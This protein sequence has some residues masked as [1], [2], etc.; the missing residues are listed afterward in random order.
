MAMQIGTIGEL[1]EW[2]KEWTQYAECLDHFLVAN[3]TR[4]SNCK[5]AMVQLVI[6]LKSK[7]LSS[8]VALRKLGEKAYEKLVKKTTVPRPPRLY[9][10]I[11]STKGL[12]TAEGRRGHVTGVDGEIT[13]IN[14][15]IMMTLT[16]ILCVLLEVVSPI[17]RSL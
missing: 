2:C 7:L 11:S 15:I 1:Q 14:F 13:K 5:H 8:L 9:S 4:N 10:T 12:S 3:R 16:H 17:G 6:G